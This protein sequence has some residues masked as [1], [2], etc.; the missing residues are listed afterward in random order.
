VDGNI[1][2]FIYVQHAIRGINY[3]KSS[4]GSKLFYF[5]FIEMKGWRVLQIMKKMSKLRYNITHFCMIKIL[6]L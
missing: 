4:K 6:Q 5:N 3:I 1:G 2:L